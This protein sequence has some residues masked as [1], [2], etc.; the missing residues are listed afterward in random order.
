MVCSTAVVNLDSNDSRSVVHSSNLGS[1][2]YETNKFYLILQKEQ[3]NR[4][5]STLYI[6]FPRMLCGVSKGTASAHR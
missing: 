5:A 3:L 2:V 6:F 4:D 1:K